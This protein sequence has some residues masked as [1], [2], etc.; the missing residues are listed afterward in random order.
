MTGAY[1]PLTHTYE[2][3]GP[4]LG[5][6]AL[7]VYQLPSP[8]T[9][10]L[11]TERLTFVVSKG[12]DTPRSPVQITHAPSHDALSF[13]DTLLSLSLSVR[14]CVACSP[15]THKV[16]DEASSVSVV[17]NW[18]AA[19]SPEP[20]CT[21]VPVA[22][23]CPRVPKLTVACVAHARVCVA[24]VLGFYKHHKDSV[25]QEFNLGP[26]QNILGVFRTNSASMTRRSTPQVRNSRSSFSN[27]TSLTACQ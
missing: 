15:R 8:P 21:H 17:S 9:Q 23:H 27:L 4:E 2:V 13:A 26:G 6:F 10:I 25:M 7:F 18:N 5:K 24:S 3:F 16:G 11:L 20:H 12:N 22:T 1:H 14:A 19:T